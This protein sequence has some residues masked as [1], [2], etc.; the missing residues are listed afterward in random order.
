MIRNLKPNL[1]T[2]GSGKYGPLS[3]AG[4]HIEEEAPSSFELM[5]KINEIIDAINRI[6]GGNAKKL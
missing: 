2:I 4:H 5:D 3:R 6:E 1:K